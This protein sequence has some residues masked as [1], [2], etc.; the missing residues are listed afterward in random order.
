MTTLTPTPA[1]TGSVT[2]HDGTTIGYRR[3]GSGP[4]VVI[5]HGA[6]EHSGSHVQLAAALADTFTVYLPDRRGRGLSGPYQPD[7]RIQTDIDDMDAVLTQTGA[8]HNV[9]G[10]SSGALIWLHA[11][12]VLPA[13][14]R[15]V[16]FEP[17]LL[18]AADSLALMKRFDEEI[19]RGK[20]AAALVTGM[21]AGRFAPPLFDLIPRFVLERLTSAMLASED[22][23]AEPDDVTVRT[24]AP[25]LRYDFQLV[26]DSQGMFDRFA[27][28]H[29]DVLLLNGGASPEYLRASVDALVPIFPRAERVVLEGLGHSA[30]GN[31][32]D[33]MTGRGADPERVARELR[34]FFS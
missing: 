5:L 16:I 4:G 23:R 32:G 11:A 6:M 25:L 20:V 3:I 22:K 9:F 34:R 26:A 27:D 33:Q 15:A 31:R 10:V 19:A 28:T 24:L 30:S 8:A 13:I 7:H 2:S 17:P 18:V 12:R 29:A 21:K 1:T 14:R